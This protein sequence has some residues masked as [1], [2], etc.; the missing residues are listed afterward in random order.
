MDINTGDLY[1]QIPGTAHKSVA[2]IMS[3]LNNPPVQHNPVKYQ[4]PHFYNL[5]IL[6]NLAL[7]DNCAY[8]RNS[9][10]CSLNARTVSVKL[11]TSQF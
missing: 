1:P 2:F 5:L 4:I 8:K 7:S 6:K 10:F 3:N 11:V 9:K